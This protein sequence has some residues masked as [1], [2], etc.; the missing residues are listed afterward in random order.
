MLKRFEE[1][2]KIA[3][4][5]SKTHSTTSYNV[6][7]NLNW[8]RYIKKLRRTVNLIPKNGKVLEIGCGFGHVTAMVKIARSDLKVI[9]LDIKK[10]S[11]WDKYKKFGCNFVIGDAQNL[12]FKDEKFDAV[13]SFGVM[14][15]IDHDAFLSEVKRVLKRGSYNFIFD[16]PNKFSFSESFLARVL[17]KF[18][19]RKIFCHEKMYT[20]REIIY[21]MK[22]YGFAYIEVLREHII[23]AQ[24]DRISKFIGRFFNKNYILIDR[25]DS[26]L[27]K[28]PLKI[29]SQTYSIHA[30]KI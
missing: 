20:E 13:I 2:R 22:K 15:H 11:T 21:L 30:K 24:V 18:L 1:V 12:K 5:Y 26:F 25:L 9:G 7:S 3:L 17:Q 16:L 4:E 27:G 29:L 6:I 8:L 28:T 23:P 19:R 14:E 10:F